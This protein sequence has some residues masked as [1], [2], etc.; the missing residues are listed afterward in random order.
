MALDLPKEKMHII[1]E[2]W[3]GASG[4]AESPT[5]QTLYVWQSREGDRVATVAALLAA[6]KKISRQ[7]A[8]DIIASLEIC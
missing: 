4:A 5:E 7:D 1:E 8:I 6:L 2:S 3:D